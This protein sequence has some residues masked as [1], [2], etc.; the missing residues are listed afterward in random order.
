MRVTCNEII[1]YTARAI[2][3]LKL[4]WGSVDISTQTIL[5]LKVTGFNSV[6][7]LINVLDKITRNREEQK[8]D[9][10]IAR[11]TQLPDDSFGKRLQFDM[12]GTSAVF[13]F[14]ILIN[15]VFE[16]LHSAK[17][18]TDSIQLQITNCYSQLLMVGALLSNE[19]PELFVS[20]I[21]RDNNKIFEYAYNS[22]SK[23]TG[24]NIFTA[25]I[26]SRENDAPLKNTLSFKISK[27]KPVSQLNSYTTHLSNTDMERLKAEAW[28]NGVIVDEHLWQ[29]V[30]Q[31]AMAILVPENSKSRLRAGECES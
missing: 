3:G 10:L 8:I 27:L 5:D 11:P 21:W 24:H 26:N 17:Q 22:S 18:K 28:Q 25:N 12:Q 29:Q 15:Y 31:Y 6:R 16:K 14:Y 19:Y 7:E 30:K 20:V 4:K 9:K 23:N 2:R 13:L 1:F